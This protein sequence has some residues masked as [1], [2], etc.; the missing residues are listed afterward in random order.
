MK[1]ITFKIFPSGKVLKIY[2]CNF[3]IINNSEMVNLVEFTKSMFVL[4][5]VCLIHSHFK[6]SGSTQDLHLKYQ[7]REFMTII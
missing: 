3:D 1:I 2:R 7:E 5:H 4:K 6:V